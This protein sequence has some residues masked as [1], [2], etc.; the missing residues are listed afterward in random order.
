VGE[1]DEFAVKVVVM[2]ALDVHLE[3]VATNDM[4]GFEEE[5]DRVVN[6]G[7]ASEQLR[8]ILVELAIDLVDVAIDRGSKY[9]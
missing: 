1:T 2:L 5:P 8:R 7:T 4:I 6:G 3:V 9:P